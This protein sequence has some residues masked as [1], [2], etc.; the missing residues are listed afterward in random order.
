M[1]TRD[2]RNSA[3]ATSHFTPEECSRPGFFMFD[4]DTHSTT[5]Q[6]EETRSF[7]ALIIGAGFSGLKP[8]ARRDTVPPAHSRFIATAL[9]ATFSSSLPILLYIMPSASSRRHF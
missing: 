1:A 3:V 5:A 4:D 9:F 8:H 6:A 7:D 2:L